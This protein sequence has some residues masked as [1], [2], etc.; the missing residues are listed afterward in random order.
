MLRVAVSQTPTEPASPR[1]LSRAR[2]RGDLPYASEW[3]FALGLLA[4][5][6]VGTQQGAAL[7]RGFE[8][9]TKAS[10]RGE[11]AW[12]QAMSL[13]QPLMLLLA[14]PALAALVCMVA[15]R[16]PTLRGAPDTAKEH[17]KRGRPS[18]GRVMQALLTGGKVFLLGASLSALVY[19]SRL[20]WLE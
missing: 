6:V 19:D 20:G 18:H 8:G 12:T 7:L 4:L 2:A 1:V 3:T 14:V 17:E 16:A 10:L 15:Q 9:L 5:M 11:R 13:L